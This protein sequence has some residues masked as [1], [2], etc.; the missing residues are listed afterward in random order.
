[1][2]CEHPSTTVFDS[3]PLKLLS[4][5]ILLILHTWIILLH[6]YFLFSCP[7]AIFVNVQKCRFCVSK[8]VL[9]MCK[10]GTGICIAFHKSLKSSSLATIP[11]E[12][13]SESNVWILVFITVYPLP[14]LYVKLHYC[15]SC[16]IHS[17]VVRNRSKENRKI[18]APPPRFPRRVSI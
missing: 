8:L 10:C 12:A 1:M 18:R 3:L 7:P 17:K 13:V 2:G 11:C 14:K 9:L 4:H 16:A 5:S 15:V 6:V